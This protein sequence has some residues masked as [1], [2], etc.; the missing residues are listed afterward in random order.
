VPPIDMGPGILQGREGFHDLV[1]L[2]AG[3]RHRRPSATGSRSG[4]GGRHTRSRGRRKT[5]K[6]TGSSQ[7]YA[8]ALGWAMPH[9][10]TPSS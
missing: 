4:Q 2:A 10:A 5:A 7:K 3:A 9:L 8:L 1:Q 6:S